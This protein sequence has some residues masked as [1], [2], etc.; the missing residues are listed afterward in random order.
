MPIQIL[1]L[2]LL[3]LQLQASS[4]S[5]STAVNE[6]LK[7]S[8]SLQKAQS[9]LSETKWK[10]VENLSGLIP[11]LSASASHLFEKKYALTDVTLGGAAVV[12]PQIIPST[13]YNLSARLP[14]FDGLANIN[15]YRS[16]VD[17]SQAAEHDFNWARF[18]LERE[19][20]LA[21]YRAIAAKRL[22]E[23]AEQ[24][25]HNLEDHLKDVRLFKKAGVSTNYDVLRVEV[26]VSEARS[27][28]LDSN[29]NVA[30]AKQKLAEALG[31]DQ[32]SREPEGNLP[33]LD[34]SV[35]RAAR[36]VKSGDRSDLQSMEEKLEGFSKL[37]KA[38][39][40]YFVP[41]I[42]LFGD[43]Q[44]Y[45]NRNSDLWNGAAF[46][47]A[48]QVGLSLNWN[49]FD[50]VT[51]IAKSR[52][53]VEQ[54]FQTEKQL[55]LAKLRAKRDYEVWKRKFLYFCS[56]YAARQNDVEKAKESMRLAR[57]GRR[58]GSRTNADLLDAETD[59]FRSQAGL[60][61]A[62]LGSIEALLNLELA[63]GQEIYRFY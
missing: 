62:Q 17:F 48:Y 38:A 30:V 63:T 12:V 35:I 36:E 54:R 18:Q 57:E 51:S 25:L 2:L 40:A 39:S 31:H 19:V 33:V 55:E 37:E 11:S 52:E 21:Y 5:L 44:H 29:D 34:A 59:L 26:Q 43:F 60:V 4:L 58:V 45:N 50:G 42:S 46:R 53:S 24:N 20:V 1:F 41:K 28:L 47:D 23:V 10:R 6:A 14:V 22:E 13:T 61:N 7:D 32:E 56:V 27:A 49:I 9:V 3:P 16:G 8:P 15:R